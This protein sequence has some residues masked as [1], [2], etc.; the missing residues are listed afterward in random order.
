MNKDTVLFS[1]VGVGFGLFFGFAF[2]SWANQRAAAVPRTAEQSRQ[3]PSNAVADQERLRTQAE[4]ASKNARD[5]PQ[6]FEAQMGAARA[7]YEAERFEDAIEFLLRANTIQ[8]SN[9]EPVV[10]LGHVN[11]DAG[12][13]SAAEKWYTAGLQMNPEN[14]TL[15]ADLGR[16]HLLSK[17]PDY[18][19]A[20]A[21]L[22]R[23]I[24]RDPRHEPSLQLLTFALAKKGETQEAR[25][26]LARLEQLNPS[27]E[28]I[29]RLREEI[30][31]AA[32]AAPGPAGAGKSGK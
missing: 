1:L 6:N 25:A 17:P 10:A 21:E 4:E 7:L 31:A 28:A 30:E 15:R 19:R 11:S 12:N 16:V 8:P 22:R 2:A 29:P 27:T 32:P 3:L 23:A 13:F 20:V 18:V 26:T 24:E 9:V 14:V 5:N